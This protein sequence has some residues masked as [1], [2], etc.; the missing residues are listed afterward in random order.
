MIGATRSG[1]QRLWIPYDGVWSPTGWRVARPARQGRELLL[2]L[3][4]LR[5]DLVEVVF[6]CLDS[7]GCRIPVFAFAMKPLRA[8][9]S[10]EKRCAHL[11]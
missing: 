11:I 2:L 1:Q 8:L 10:L 7:V 9:E 5:L 4:R 3:A 6:K